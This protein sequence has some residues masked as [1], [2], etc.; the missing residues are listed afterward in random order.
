M[1]K[2]FIMT[3][4]LPGVGKSANIKEETNGIDKFVVISTDAIRAE[5]CGDPSDQSHNKEVFELAHS[6]IK[7][8]LNSEQYILNPINETVDFAY[9]CSHH[10][11]SSFVS[12]HP[13]IISTLWATIFKKKGKLKLNRLSNGRAR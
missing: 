6:R 5:L 4:G 11:E 13:P 8:F 9:C 1:K 3:C 10:K 7:E 12:L 2:R